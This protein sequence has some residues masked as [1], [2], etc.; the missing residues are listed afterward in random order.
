MSSKKG[1]KKICKG[2]VFFYKYVHIMIRLQMKKKVFFC[3]LKQIMYSKIYTFL[4]IFFKKT[5]ISIL[6]FIVEVEGQIQPTSI[7]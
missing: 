1:I 6:E 5:P 7:S 3:I 2:N 4:N